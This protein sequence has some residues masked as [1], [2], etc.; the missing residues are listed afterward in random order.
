MIVSHAPLRL[1]LGGGGSDLHP[2]G[3]CVTATISPSITVIVSQAFTHDN[4]LI[5]YST[6]ERAPRVSDIQHPIIRRA[7]DALG[8]PPGVEITSVADV[9]GGTGLGSSGAF[10]VAVLHAF[11][12]HLGKPLTSLE[13]AEL[14]CEVDPVGWQDQMS[15]V[16]GG[17]RAYTRTNN[18]PIAISL[19]TR[20]ALDTNLLLFYTGQTR[21]S[22]D[23]LPL[24]RTDPRATAPIARR[25]VIAL[26]RGHMPAFAQ[27]LTDQWDLKYEA[28]PSPLHAIADFSIKDAIS[29]DLALGGKLIGAG[30]G[31][32][33]LFYTENPAALR[34]AI[35]YK[36]LPFSLVDHGV[37]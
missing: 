26:E 27:T 7:V 30:D 29:R 25:A 18:R 4:Y 9:P 34:R 22:S 21:A 32:F 12:A 16:Y 36:E 3:L 31:G 1:T 13:L 33:I 5:R 24:A 10:A 19:S 23:V 35:T 17:L 28:H 37:R 20:R 8:V 15:A 2:N 14:A 6:I 11:A